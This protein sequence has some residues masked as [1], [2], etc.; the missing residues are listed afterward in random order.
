[1]DSLPEQ[2]PTRIA[3][4][5]DSIHPRARASQQPASLA[6]GLVRLGAAAEV[7]KVHA[8]VLARVPREGPLWREEE[9]LRVA[10]QNADADQAPADPDREEE[11]VLGG[12]LDFCPDALIAYDGSSPAAWIGARASAR[13]R[14][15]L[16]LI[17]PAWTSMRSLRDRV[18]E[19]LGRRL[20]GRLVRSQTRHVF[21]MDPLAQRLAMDR[22]YG[23]SRIELL[24]VGVDCETFRP[25]RP[26]AWVTRFALRGRILLYVGPLE[27]GRGVEM[28]IRAFARSIG[29]REDWCLVLAGSGS[30]SHR[31]V[32]LASRLG[33]AD[34]V[35]P[36]PYPTPEELP[37]LMGAST[38][39]AV[40]A[41]DDRTRG[42]QIPRALAC[43]L[44][45]IAT[46]LERIAWQLADGEQGLLFDPGD[47][48]QLRAALARAASSPE[49]RRR[50]S[51]AGRQRALERDWTKIAGIVLD[52]VQREIGTYSHPDSS[53]D[54]PIERR[55]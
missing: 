1:M 31:C 26:T 22:G 21:A 50:W 49:L 15:P 12:L 40:P 29:Q 24:P 45:V 52:G 8:G 4:L 17:E 25:G 13:L 14:R 10:A 55:A 44:P 33:I 39:M 28:L 7:V 46:D 30:L 53:A 34:R 35:H 41:V 18:L 32:V 47:E 5:V 38:L 43:G 48:E 20:W 51:A 36:V 9:R 19:G 54:A 6:A 23:A 27:P 3:L 16:L 2:R 11:A 37:G 42:A